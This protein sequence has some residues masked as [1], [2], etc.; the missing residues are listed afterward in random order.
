MFNRTLLKIRYLFRVLRIVGP[1]ALLNTL[2]NQIYRHTTQ[3]IMVRDFNVTDIPVHCDIKYT[4]RQATPEDMAIILE[5]AR[6]EDKESARQLLLRVLL[7]ECGFHHCYIAWD[8]ATGEPCQMQWMITPEDIKL[9][10]HPFSSPPTTLEPDQIMAEYSFTF[11]KYRR[12]GLGA[13][14]T[15]DTRKIGETMGF[16]RGTGYVERKNLAQ[17]KSLSSIGIRIPEEIDELTLFFF[18][19]RRRRKYRETETEEVKESA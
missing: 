14:V 18:T 8:D 2:K 11:N 17:M 12:R 5:K 19:I 3:V 7:Y 16:T 13:A 9:H 4:L 6:T 15:Y 1:L 10:G